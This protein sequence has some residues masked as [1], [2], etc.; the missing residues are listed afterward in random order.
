MTTVDPSRTRT[1][2]D[3]CLISSWGATVVPLGE[4][5]ELQVK[6]PQVMLGYYNDAEA[7]KG[8]VCAAQKCL[9]L[10]P[11]WQWTQHCRS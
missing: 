4:R 2:V 10:G 6:G 7:T 5:G 8:A 9:L 11:P 3:T 1:M